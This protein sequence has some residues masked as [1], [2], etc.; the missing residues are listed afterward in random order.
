ML[1]IVT[2]RCKELLD[3]TA[4]SLPPPVAPRNAVHLLGHSEDLLAVDKP[5]GLPC[6]PGRKPEL[7]DCLWHRLQQTHPEALVVHRLDMATSGVMVFAR[8][9]AAQAALSQAFAQRRVHKRYVA[10]VHGVMPV[11]P[12]EGVIDAPMLAD[13]PNRPR[14]RIDFANGRQA[15]TRWRVMKHHATQTLLEL[16]PLT[17]RSHQLRVHLASIG[18]PIV[19]DT[20][21]GPD[22][23]VDA[24]MPPSPAPSPM[25]RMHLHAW[26][27]EG[28]GL[29]QAGQS[30]VKL[31]KAGS[32][33]W[34][35]ESKL[36]SWASGDLP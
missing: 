9:A 22:A 26:T 4:N 35:F 3:P 25:P 32:K 18:H 14:Q 19:G 8:H 7:M 29:G 15:I 27:L 28:P 12:I 33:A 13:W 36:P 34:R 2:K 11:A 17:G 24:A 21:Y 23:A 10:L 6:V 31:G 20:L 16:T 30:W 1:N 5:A